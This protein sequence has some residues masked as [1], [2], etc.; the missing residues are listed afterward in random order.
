MDV[1]IVEVEKQGQE[2]KSHTGEMLI[3]ISNLLSKLLLVIYH[4]PVLR[5]MKRLSKLKDI[6]AKDAAKN[7]PNG[8]DQPAPAAPSASPRALSEMN[9]LLCVGSVGGRKS[10][11]ETSELMQEGVLCSGCGIEI[12]GEG[13]GVLRYCEDCGPEKSKN[14]RARN[15]EWSANF[16]E[17][18]G[19]HF[20]TKNNGAHLIVKHGHITADFWPGTG[21]WIDRAIGIYSRG[22][23]KLVKHLE[24]EAG[25]DR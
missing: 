20:E 11:G 16:L 23:R 12:E 25:G 3:F 19:I 15:R 13:D 17:S 22:V 1:L 6:S 4:Q 10:M 7:F 8:D 9:R 24:L 2:V 18:K 5:E 14:K 21:K